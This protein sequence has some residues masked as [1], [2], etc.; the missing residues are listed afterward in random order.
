[1]ALWIEVRLG[2]T[3]LNSKLC[4]PYIHIYLKFNDKKV[5]LISWLKSL[6]NIMCRFFYRLFILHPIC[7]ILLRLQIFSWYHLHH[8]HQNAIQNYS[9]FHLWIQRMMK[10]VLFDF[11]E[12]HTFNT[13]PYS[14]FSAPSSLN[15]A[16]SI[17]EYDPTLHQLLH[18]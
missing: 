6:N 3:D 5:W 16:R 1:M 13:N 8:L 18:H 11:S 4:W 17:P 14:L 7:F 2:D 12:R 10:Q 15:L 9:A